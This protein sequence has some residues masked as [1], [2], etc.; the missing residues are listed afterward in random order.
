VACGCA[1]EI[2]QIMPRG[3]SYLW[4]SLPRWLYQPDNICGTATFFLYV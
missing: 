3:L 4:T 1:D 2:L